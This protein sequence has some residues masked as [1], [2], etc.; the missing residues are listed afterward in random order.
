MGQLTITQIRQFI[1]TLNYLVSTHAAEELEDD[2]L[3]ILDF[4]NVVLTGQV[5]ERQRDEKSGEIKYLIEGLTIEGA[6]A[7]TVVKVGLTSKLIV[8]TAYVC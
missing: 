6:K 3:T 1:R 8:I 7:A 5:V 2:D 4:E